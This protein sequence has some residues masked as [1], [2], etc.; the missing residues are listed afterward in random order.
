MQLHAEQPS[1]IVGCEVHPHKTNDGFLKAS[2]NSPKTNG[3][4]HNSGPP[5][6][7][8]GVFMASSNSPKTKAFCY[9]QNWGPNRYNNN[10]GALTHRIGRVQKS[11]SRRAIGKNKGGRHVASQTLKKSLEMILKKSDYILLHF[12]TIVL[13]NV[14]KM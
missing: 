9:S 5:I 3:I 6:I 14:V 11:F 8:D 1:I 12:S 13:H 7:N 4:L 10:K 2:S